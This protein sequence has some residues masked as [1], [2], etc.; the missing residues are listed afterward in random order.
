MLSFA[1]ALDEIVSAVIDTVDRQATYNRTTAETVPAVQDAVDGQVVPPTPPPTPPPAV[2]P[3]AVAGAGGPWS[4]RSESDQ[5]FLEEV[6]EIQAEQAA[7][8][9][10]FVVGEV[11]VTAT[12]LYVDVR[13]TVLNVSVHERGNLLYFTAHFD[14]PPAEVYFV[15]TR[16]GEERPIADPGLGQDG[17]R[18]YAD[19]DDYTVTV[20]TTGFSGGVLHWHL[21]GVDGDGEPVGSEFGE[22]SIRPRKPQLL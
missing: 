2:L 16:P 19:G 12:S 8:R 13:A 6:A 5:D 21:W 11:V 20:D 15:Y 3:T 22:E 4:D 7:L 18:I 10:E 14:D 1:R 17:S 9:G